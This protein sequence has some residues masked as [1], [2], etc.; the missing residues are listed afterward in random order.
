[1]RTWIVFFKYKPIEGPEPGEEE[2][3]E[4]FGCWAKVDQVWSK[5]VELAKSN[6]TL[7]DVTITIRDPQGD[8]Y[9]SNKDH[10]TISAPQY[11][12]VTFNVKHIQPDM[13]NKDFIKVIA[14]VMS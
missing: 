12:N 1:M 7:T 6:G 5:D 9:P 3:E 13:Q 4:L 14:E 10:I 8:Y 11:Q 2:E